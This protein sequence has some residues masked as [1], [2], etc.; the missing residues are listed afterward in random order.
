MKSGELRGIEGETNEE[1]FEL[2]YLH[3]VGKTKSK[4]LLCTNTKLLTINRILL[5]L[6]FTK[7][8]RV[9]IWCEAFTAKAFK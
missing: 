4:C 2:S 7:Y 1:G 6:T 3:Y 9:R 5:K 8:V